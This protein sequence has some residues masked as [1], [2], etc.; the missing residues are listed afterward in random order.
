M[1]VTGKRALT[2]L[3]E[4]SL[5]PP[6]AS[7][8]NH[9]VLERRIAEALEQGYERGFAAGRAAVPAEIE[10]LI[11][12]LAKRYDAMLADASL[13]WQRE[14]S[15]NLL[16]MLRTGIAAISWSIE[17]SVARLLKPWLL[18]KMHQQAVREF[19][20]SLERVITEGSSVEVSGPECLVRE[21]GE[22]VAGRPVRLVLSP[23]KE[24]AV[25]IKIDDTMILANFSEWVSRLDGVR[26]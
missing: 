4:F 15:E 9:Q 12:E 11:S 25:K 7:E 18:E 26:T 1:R 21:I 10:G 8:L 2:I 24:A 3:E 22:L 19:H 5:G 6:N 20:A 13:A 14:T 16:E 17:Q 23:S